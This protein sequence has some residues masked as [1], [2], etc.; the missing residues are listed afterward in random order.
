ME[1]LPSGW[2]HGRF[3][4]WIMDGAS[5]EEKTV[6]TGNV[7][8]PVLAVISGI[9]GRGYRKNVAPVWRS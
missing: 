7:P 1:T 3:F 2:Y 8:P 6:V 5:E 9:F 4:A